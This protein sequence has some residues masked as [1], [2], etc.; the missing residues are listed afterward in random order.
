MK[1]SKFQAMGARTKCSSERCDWR[2]PRKRHLD[3]GARMTRAS[4]YDICWARSENEERE[5]YGERWRARVSAIKMNRLRKVEI[6]KDSL[7]HA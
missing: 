7:A 1:L 4:D 5:F 6:E 2:E 3:R